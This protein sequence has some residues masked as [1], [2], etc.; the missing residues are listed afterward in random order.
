MNE[1]KDDIDGSERIFAR[2]TSSSNR[3][4]LFGGAN[5]DD[6]VIKKSVST[7]TY[8]FQD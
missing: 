5:N 8:F 2:A 3:R 6:C 1:W 4:I 7:H